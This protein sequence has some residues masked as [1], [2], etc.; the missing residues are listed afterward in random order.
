MLKFLSKQK[1]RATVKDRV[2]EMYQGES[3]RETIRCFATIHNSSS[4]SFVNCTVRQ[5]THRN[6]GFL[7]YAYWQFSVYF[8][9]PPFQC[10]RIKSCLVCSADLGQQIWTVSTM[11][12]VSLLLPFFLSHP[13]P[14]LTVPP[15]FFFSCFPL[16]L[17]LPPLFTICYSPPLPSHLSHL[18][19]FRLPSTLVFTLSS[20]I[21][22]TPR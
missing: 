13:P 19:Q 14:V 15:S 4:V 21:L 18:L 12:V 22:L 3:Q 17:P 7:W 16:H 8:I 9:L 10:E 2:R 11:G 6:Q 1:Q 20:L 5:S